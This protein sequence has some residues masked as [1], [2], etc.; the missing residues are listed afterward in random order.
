MR[1]FLILTFTLICNWCLAAAT[2]ET[3]QIYDIISSLEYKH[4]YPVTYK[5]VDQVTGDTTCVVFSD[6][7]E[8][9]ATPRNQ[10]FWIRDLKANKYWK[11]GDNNFDLN[12]G[13]Y[14]ASNRMFSHG[15]TYIIIIYKGDISVYDWGDSMA[16]ASIDKILTELK[17][18]SL[19]KLNILE[20]VINAQ[21]NSHFFGKLL[22][23]TSISH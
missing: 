14:S 23:Q 1:S 17:Y 13:L 6:G 22:I 2:N 9:L 12:F 18:S 21:I 5:N 19:D 10:R 7:S 8:F 20:N 11:K 4:S 16:I 15:R 3:L